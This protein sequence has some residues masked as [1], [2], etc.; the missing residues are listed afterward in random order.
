M[1]PI[2]I[3]RDGSVAGTYFFLATILAMVGLYKFF[4]VEENPAGYSLFITSGVIAAI[5]T[6]LSDPRP[7]L[8]ID[9]NGIKPKYSSKVNWIEIH[10]IE[11]ERMSFGNKYFTEIRFLNKAGGNL[12]SMALKRNNIGPKH[13]AKQIELILHENHQDHIQIIS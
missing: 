5:A 3:K 10:Q 2:E 7:L 12:F 9:Q 13:L 4:I 1:K 6:F 11:F 8:K